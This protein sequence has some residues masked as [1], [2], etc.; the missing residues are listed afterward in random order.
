MRV[1]ELT[2]K[3]NIFKFCILHIDDTRR[4][5]L[6]EQEHNIKIE[7]G[8]ISKDTTDYFKTLIKLMDKFDYGECRVSIDKKYK[9]IITKEDALH[10]IGR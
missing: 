6:Y 1:T 9:G 4:V 2:L 5:V 7:N 8:K 10:F 3:D